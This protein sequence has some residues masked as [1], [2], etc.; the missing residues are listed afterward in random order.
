MPQRSTKRAKPNDAQSAKRT[1]NGW[2]AVAKRQEESEKR[3]E[4]QEAE[5]DRPREFWLKAGEN[6]NIQLLHD[7]PYTFDCHSIKDKFGNFK[8]I[9]CQLSVQKHCLMCTEGLKMGWKGAYKV[10]DFRGTWD[11]EK[12]RF[13][14]DKPVEKIWLVNMTILGQLQAQSVKRKKPLDEMVLNISRTGKGK[15]DTSYNFEPAT[16]DDD[17]RMRPIDFD[18]EFPSVKTLM[19]PLSDDALEL[20]GFEK[21][22]ED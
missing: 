7:E 17:N 13:K 4:L 10:L 8:T 14:N 12:K 1:T 22:D 15:N 18:E 21:P 5:G 2:A 11:K 16:D 6:A 20:L 3:K 19:K 9:P